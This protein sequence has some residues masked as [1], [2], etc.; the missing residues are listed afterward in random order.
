MLPTPQKYTAFPRIYRAGVKSTV[1]IVPEGRTFLFPE[2]V[3]Y[4]VKISGINDDEPWYHSPSTWDVFDVVAKNGVLRFDYVFAAEQEYQLRLYRDE[5]D[6]QKLPC[7]H[8]RKTS[9]RSVL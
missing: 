3:T 2:N 4:T 8:W 7:T 9:M 1:T 5:L 6:V